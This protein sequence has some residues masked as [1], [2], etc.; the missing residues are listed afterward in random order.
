EA[1]A[2]RVGLGTVFAVLWRIVQ[3]PLVLVFLFVSFEIVY[4][5]APNLGRRP[6]R[7]WWSPGAATAVVLWLGASYGYRVYLGYFHAYSKTYGSLGAVI[8][9]LIWFYMTGFALLMGGE[10]NSE[11]ARARGELPKKPPPAP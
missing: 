11:I 5:Y 1:L 9:L 2:Q 3:W 6:R 7:E 4:N 8:L 10:V